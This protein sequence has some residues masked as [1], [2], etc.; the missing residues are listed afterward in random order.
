ML[1]HARMNIHYDQIVSKGRGGVCRKKPPSGSGPDCE[2][3][4]GHILGQ[5]LLHR[6]QCRG[7]FT[8]LGREA[9]VETRQVAVRL[10]KID[11]YTDLGHRI[12]ST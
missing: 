6:E 5:S 9:G 12:N 1:I 3:D 11:V 8:G 2:T 4:S 7:D 10:E